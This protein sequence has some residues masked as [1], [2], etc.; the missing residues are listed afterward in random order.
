MR[1]NIDV[2]VAAVVKR[3]SKYLIVEELVGGRRVFN[4]PAGHVETGETLLEAVVREMLEETGCQ[5][6]PRAFIGIFSWRGESRNYL[7][8]AFSGDAELPSKEPALDEGIVATHWL[9]KAE[10]AQRRSMLRSPMVLNCVSR[11]EE[12]T[13]YP[14]SVVCELLSEIDNIAH[15]A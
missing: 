4:Q 6:I 10:L 1:P 9:S 8:I 5:F 12:G 14:L 7:R 3:D 2:T 15:T 13:E 11:Y